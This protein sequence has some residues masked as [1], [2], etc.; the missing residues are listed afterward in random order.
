VLLQT[1]GMSVERRAEWLVDPDIAYLNHGGYGALPRQVADAAEHWRLRT[2]ANPSQLLAHDWQDHVDRV[3]QRLAEF[4]NASTTDL[5]F[6]ANATTGTA[7]VISSLNLGA[8]DEIVST[9]HRYPAVAQQLAVAADASGVVVRVAHIPLDVATA[10][11]IV[12]A[13]M[14][15]VTERTKLVVVDHIASA[16][17]FVFPVA[18]IAAA[19]HA[20]G[21]PVLIDAAHAPGQLDVDLTALGVDFWVGNLHKWVCSPR[22][23]AV[24]YVAPEWQD[25]VRP[26][27]PSWNFAGGF[28][29]AFDWQGTLDPVPLLTIPDALDFWAELG[30]DNVRRQQRALATDGAHYAAAAIGTGVAIRDEFTAAMRLVKLPMSMDLEQSVAVSKA[31]GSE[32]GV[33][34]YVTG[35]SGQSFVRVCG[36][37][38]NTPDDYARLADTLRVILRRLPG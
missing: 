37:L 6:V 26:L 16:T 10:D 38:Y 29:P 31:M 20:A 3:R 25:V 35:H 15:A 11:E 17:G 30:W 5:V 24:M 1:V 18:Q 21:V 19:A 2:E 27:V 28:Q 22:A 13:I 14:T 8:G 4:L 33:V 23:C 7:S 34:A 9:D 12:S 32:F 36:Q